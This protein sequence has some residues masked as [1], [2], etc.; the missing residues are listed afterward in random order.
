ME[1]AVKFLIISLLPVNLEYFA[2]QIKFMTWW[3]TPTFS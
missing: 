2:F 3:E 1:D